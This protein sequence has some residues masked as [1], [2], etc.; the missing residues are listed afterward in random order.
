MHCWTLGSKRSSREWE[1][2]KDQQI[3]G[4]LSH[5][6]SLEQNTA[7]FSEEG[8]IVKILGSESLSQVPNSAIVAWKQ[9]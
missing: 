2:K 4:S 3:Q 5:A 8:Q 7:T 9:F 6:L 1:L